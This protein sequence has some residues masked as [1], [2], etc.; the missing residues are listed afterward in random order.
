MSIE[1]GRRVFGAGVLLCAL[2]AL[3]SGGCGGY[4]YVYYPLLYGAPQFIQ[5]TNNAEWD[6]GTFVNTNDTT[7][8]GTVRL[9]ATSTDLVLG[10]F[11]PQGTWTVTVD[12]GA[13]GTLWDE[14]V[15]NTEAEA[16]IPAGTSLTVALRA[17]DDQANLL[18]LPFVPYA[19]GSTLAGVVGRFLEIQATFTGGSVVK[20]GDGSTF[21]LAGDT[22]VL[23]DITVTTKAPPTSDLIEQL[24]LRR[25]L[26][27]P[28]H[29]VTRPRG[30]P[31]ALR[32][33]E[34]RPAREL[35]PRLPGGVRADRIPACRDGCPARPRPGEVTWREDRCDGKTVGLDRS[36]SP[37][38]ARRH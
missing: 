33:A 24:A 31:A 30:S 9:D 19:S 22:P 4:G 35:G 3:T 11:V 28:R 1:R 2:A 6:L 13:G 18:L 29:G 8:P 21:G 36:S 5:F 15:W 20:P 34:I 12:S 37:R 23:S 26:R 14:I 7:V 16:L 10:G 27:H 32:E 38:S 25:A 17:A